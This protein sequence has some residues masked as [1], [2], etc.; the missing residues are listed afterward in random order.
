MK[1]VIFFFFPTS[2]FFPLLILFYWAT[3]YRAESLFW[4]MSSCNIITLAQRKSPLEI[5]NPNRPLF[6]LQLFEYMTSDNPMAN[7]V[8]NSNCS[9]GN[10]KYREDFPASLWREDAGFLTLLE[11]GRA[12]KLVFAHGSIAL[13]PWWHHGATQVTSAAWSRAFQAAALL[14]STM[15]KQSLSPLLLRVL[16]WL[17]ITE[18]T[19][20]CT[21]ANRLICKAVF[22]LLWTGEVFHLH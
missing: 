22:G 16:L 19:N 2:F 9:H 18:K 8:P 14:T 3:A 4:L 20:S 13:E 1:I 17:Q 10:F 12:G 11:F 15:Y 21:W 6:Y 7:C 5:S